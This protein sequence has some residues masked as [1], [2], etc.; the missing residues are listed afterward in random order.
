MKIIYRLHAIERMFERNIS[1][2]AVPN[3]INGGKII[4]DYPDDKP[5]P[6][7]LILGYVNNKPVHVVC[8]VNKAKDE[9]IIITVYEPD[10][11]K[12]NSNFERR[13]K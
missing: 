5:Y 3:V 4:E 2:E 10:K 8:A 1:V 9:I 13:I 12:W 6:S 7:K 11:E